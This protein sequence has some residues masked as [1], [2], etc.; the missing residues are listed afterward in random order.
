VDPTMRSVS[1]FYLQWF[2]QAFPA[3]V[4]ENERE[5]EAWLLLRIAGDSAR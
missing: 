4:A 2:P 1:K 5:A 3:I